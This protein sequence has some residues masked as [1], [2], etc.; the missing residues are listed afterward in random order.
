MTF[1]V[2]AAWLHAHRA[3]VAVVDMQSE[4]KL[5]ERGHLAG[6]VH[7]TVEDFRTDRKLL[8]PRAELERKLGALGIDRDTHV[9]VYDEKYGRNAGWLWF[10]L[11]QL[12]HRA[13]SLLD[14]HLD[15]WKDRLETGPPPAVAP[16]TYRARHD[17]TDLVDAV[18]VHARL[19]RILLLDA[20]P[21]EQYT[22]VKPKK[23][24]MGGHIPGAVNVPWDSFLGPDKRYL[25]EEAARAV[26]AERVARRITKE[27]PI[28][29]Y[30]NSYPQAAHLHF[31]LARLGYANLKAF[32]GSM[33]EWEA[34]GLPRKKGARP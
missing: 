13:V 34:Q 6:A 28:V 11:T 24:M 7:A 21:T 3:E 27:T 17:P 15:A 14:G 19:G 10:T 22:G 8:R 18:W 31:Q 1:L 5:Y 16:R 2:D 33:R 4:R 29:L 20:R 23:G 9:V 26:L 12:G 30:C 25:D 32:D